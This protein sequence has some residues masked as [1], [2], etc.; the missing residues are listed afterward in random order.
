LFLYLNVFFKWKELVSV[1]KF[2]ISNTFNGRGEGA[3]HDS[4]TGLRERGHIGRM[5]EE[6]PRGRGQDSMEECKKDWEPI[7]GWEEGG[8]TRQKSGEAAGLV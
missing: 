7:E 3:G 1:Y 5:E 2:K 4:R 6:V 8:R